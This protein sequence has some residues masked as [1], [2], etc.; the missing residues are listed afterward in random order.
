MKIYGFKLQSSAG[1]EPDTPLRLR[2]AT[3]VASSDELRHLARFLADTADAVDR[4]GNQFGH[5]HFT[6]Y[7]KKN[8]IA[9]SADQGDLILVRAV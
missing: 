3:L 1:D 5:E 9:A 8:N 6:D 4:F 2:E 7:C